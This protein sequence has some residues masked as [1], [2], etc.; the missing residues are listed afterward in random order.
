[1]KLISELSTASHGLHQPT[2]QPVGQVT[3]PKFG[4]RVL[5]ILVNT[6]NMAD[7]GAAVSRAAGRAAV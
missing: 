5:I 3:A 4:P 7:R 1:M 6:S 2:H